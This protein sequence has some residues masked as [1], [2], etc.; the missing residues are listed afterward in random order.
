MATALITA[1]L[2][3]YNATMD[4]RREVLAALPEEERAAAAQK[5]QARVDFF[6][7]ILERMHDRIHGLVDKIKD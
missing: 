4:Y 6:F 1:M 7:G 2:H 5:L 3:A